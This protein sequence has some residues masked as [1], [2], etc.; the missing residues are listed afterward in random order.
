MT[1]P[2][3]RVVITGMGAVTNLGHDAKSSWAAMRAGQSGVSA[4][5][6]PAFEKYEGWNVGIAGQVKKWNT[7][8]F[9]ERR[10][11][12]RLDRCTQLGL[13][14]FLLG[15]WGGVLPGTTTY[16][17]IGAAVRRISAT[18]ARLQSTERKR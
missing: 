13:G 2:T 18:A 9:L 3:N 1:A 7:D 15:T 8:D 12:K 10:E 4:L 5:E 6:D 11:A 17:S 14:P 16:C